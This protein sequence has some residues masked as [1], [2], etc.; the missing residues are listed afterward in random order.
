MKR[1][2][3]FCILSV[4][5]CIFSYF[6]E[7]LHA[8]NTLTS[9]IETADLD[10]DAVLSISSFGDVKNVVNG[11]MK[12]MAIPGIPEDILGEENPNIP[13]GLS[14]SG[15]IGIIVKGT[16]GPIPSL[17]GFIP[18]TEDASLDSIT[19]MFSFLMGLNPK[20]E[21]NHFLFSTTPDTEVPDASV[22]GGL[23]ERY[24]V[25]FQLSVSK[26][27]PFIPL[28]AAQ[29]GPEV[30]MKAIQTLLKETKT[31]LVGL[32]TDK[33][34]G[35]LFLDL[36]MNPTPDSDTEKRMAK[37]AT[38]KSKVA[39]F[40]D[41]E[42][43][44][45][46]QG[47]FLLTSD[48]A[49]NMI[50][51]INDDNTIEDELR[52]I[53]IGTIKSGKIDVAFSFNLKYD[54]AKKEKGIGFAAVSI[55]DGSLVKK[56]IETK[57]ESGDWEVEMDF[58]TVGKGIKAHRVTLETGTECVVGLSKKFCFVAFG[59]EDN[60]AVLKEKIKETLNAPD[61]KTTLQ[62]HYD[63]GKL[64]QEI[65]S[66]LKGKITISAL[67][68][69]NNSSARIYIPQDALI[70]LYHTLMSTMSHMGDDINID[71]NEND[72]N[73]TDVNMIDVTVEESDAEES[74][75]SFTLTPYEE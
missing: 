64:P 48:V 71:L 65:S 29:A 27:A 31:I 22:L 69:E 19:E 68:S 10:Q 35:D 62:G 33:S 46:F 3:L 17:T 57:G 40:Y 7:A 14:D 44:A 32:G 63:L 6:T 61:P 21:E 49:K 34:S 47:T 11:I 58:A 13:K 9:P 55:H 51:A 5:V 18:V 26:L 1:F 24:L 25:A 74:D 20:I 8:Q 2:T 28:L 43:M 66:E 41:P 45:G 37:M 4:M 50:Q 12:K 70:S 59:N 16:K 60:L 42:F 30:D 67:T 23:N 53:L 15:P 75:D 73:M 72:L 36:A 54:D 52:E 39:G 56:F 38:L